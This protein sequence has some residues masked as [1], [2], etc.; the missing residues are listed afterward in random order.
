MIVCDFHIDGATVFPSETNAPL[1]IDADDDNQLSIGDPL[2][3]SRQS[4]GELT[5]PDLA[6]FPILEGLYHPA[7]LT[8]FVINV[9]R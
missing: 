6:G 1:L 4:A 8:L 5:I 2:N 9:K 7:I 3:L